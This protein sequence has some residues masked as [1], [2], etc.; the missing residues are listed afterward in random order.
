MARFMA[1]LDRRI[2]PIRDDLAATQLA[3]RIDAPNYAEA[4][5]ARLIVGHTPLRN[6]PSG[7][8]PLDS[9]L[10]FG[11]RVDIYESKGGWA[12]VQNQTDQYVGFVDSAA[13][14]TT[15]NDA[16]ATP[17]HRVSALRTYLYPEP[18]LKT[19]PLDLL[20]LSSEVTVLDERNG[21]GDS[22][23]G[24]IW[25]GHVSP[26]DQFETNI[27]AVACA[28]LGTPYLW[29]GRTSVGLDCSAFVQL[30][31]A[32]CGIQV[33]RDTDMQENALSK[34]DDWS[35]EAEMLEPGDLI[36]W[37]GH[38]AI[39]IGQNRLI[40]ANATHMAVTVGPLQDIVNHI[41]QATGEPVSSVRRP[42]FSQ[43]TS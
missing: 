6:A 28:F 13:L 31:L 38:V 29:G 17:S 10:L 37:K 3:D 5:P 36:F 15:E 27:V 12:W 16:D 19:P 33:P 23:H 8:A 42:N 7:K 26:V 11:E 22:G 14:V 1:D 18:D 24:W 34:L 9:E 25:G 41:E 4:T 20:S 39:W 30:A 40:H 35:G 32:S 2:H 43:R 21:F